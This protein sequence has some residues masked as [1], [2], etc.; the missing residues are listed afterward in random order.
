MQGSVNTDVFS[1][2][3][4]MGLQNV[5]LMSGED[6]IGHV[7]L[8]TDMQS[9]LQTYRVE[10]PVSPHYTQ[11]PQTGAM[12]VGLGPLRPYLPKNSS[13]VDLLTG[14]VVWIAPV[15]GR[16]KDAYTQFVSEIIVAAPS[17]LNSILGSD[18]VQ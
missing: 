16:M 8:E 7:F 14:H 11:D 1:P 13:S 4:D 5:H 10:K 6:I 17:D 9:G 3:I 15:E 12:R 2:S 18:K